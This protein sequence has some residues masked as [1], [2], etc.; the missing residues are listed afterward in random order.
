MREC[1]G[2]SLDWFDGLHPALEYPRA[3]NS[4]GVAVPCSASTSRSARHADLRAAENAYRRLFGIDA[5]LFREGRLAAGEWATLPLGKG[6]EDADAAGIE[7]GMVALRRDEFVL[8][9]F[10]GTRQPAPCTRSVSGSRPT[11][12][13]PSER[14]CRRTALHQHTGEDFFSSTISSGSA[15]RSRNSMFPS[16]AQER[17]QGAGSRSAA[18]SVE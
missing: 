12:S 8:A 9:L 1:A 18:P 6:W 15:G 7:V 2:M 16:R 17:S 4:E 3:A 11:R 13:T 5:I 10:Q 14:D